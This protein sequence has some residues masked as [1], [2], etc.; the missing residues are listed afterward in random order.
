[1]QRMEVIYGINPIKILLGQ[2]KTGL[3]KVYIASGRGGTSVK[4]IIKAARQKNIPVEYRTKQYLDELVGNSDHQGVAGLRPA[5]V[6]SALDDLIINRG[7][8]HSFSLIL[9]LDSIMDP[10]NLGSIIRTSYCLGANGVVIPADRAAPV[11]A[12][13][14]KASAGSAG[15]LPVARVANLSQAIDYLKEKKFWVFG[16]DAHEG[17]NLREMDFNCHVALVLGGEAKGI[18]PLVKKKCDFLLSIPQTRSFDSLNVAVAAGI[19]QY[20]IFIQ[21]KHAEARLKNK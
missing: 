13:V 14:V 19:V 21:R 6:Y 2:E 3:E 15:Q 4:E 17:G 12:A 18:R 11:T 16:A 1:V 5:F 8:P 20:E 10:Q 9:I 7:T